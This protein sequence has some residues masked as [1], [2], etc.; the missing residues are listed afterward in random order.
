[1]FFGIPGT[2][3][4]RHMC[5]QTKQSEYYITKVFKPPVCA[6]QEP[7]SGSYGFCSKE[8]ITKLGNQKSGSK[9]KRN[10]IINGQK[11]ER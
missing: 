11:E 9:I 1:M 8:F 2:G 7:Y 4:I 10:S 3:K 6:Y 5:T